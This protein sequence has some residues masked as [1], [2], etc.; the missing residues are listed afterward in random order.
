MVMFQK[1][2]ASRTK[3]F[4]RKGPQ[5]KPVH[6]IQAAAKWRPHFSGSYDWRDHSGQATA[7]ENMP[8]GFIIIDDM[9]ISGYPGRRLPQGLMVGQWA[10]LSGSGVACLP[11]RMEV[12][13]S[14]M[15][16]DAEHIE[17]VGSG[18]KFHEYAKLQN[19][20]KL[21]RIGD[22]FS[23]RKWLELRDCPALEYLPDN[24][25]V[26]NVLRI[27]GCQ[28]LRKLPKGMTVGCLEIIN[29]PNIEAIP[30]DI[31]FVG[32]GLLRDKVRVKD[33]GNP[34]LMIPETYFERD[35]VRYLPHPHPAAPDLSGPTPL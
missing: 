3:N 24:I 5:K 9:N 15:M 6:P 17:H 33:C 22:G 10:Q 28:N 11:D 12:F 25:F 21:Q 19:L 8:D 30:D 23:V 26:G 1:K 7:V 18:V 4:R 14:F 16:S 29:C 27:E 34:D 13:G 20:P 32:T 35:L 2:F 31:E